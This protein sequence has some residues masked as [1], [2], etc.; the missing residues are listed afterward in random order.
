MIM[1]EMD[2]YETVTASAMKEDEEIIRGICGSYL[3]KPVNKRVAGFC[4]K[5]YGRR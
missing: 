1:P 5:I 4:C 3:K 2:G